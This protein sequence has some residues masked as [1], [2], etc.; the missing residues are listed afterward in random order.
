MSIKEKVSNDYIEEMKNKHA[1]KL[2]RRH[3][4]ILLT[5]AANPSSIGQSIKENA[6]IHG[7][8][9]AVVDDDVTQSFDRIS[10]DSTADTLI[11]CHGAMHLDWIENTPIED[12]KRV[13][14]VNLFGTINVVR[15]FV[16]MSLNRPNR[17]TII[18]IGSMA[19]NKVLN[20]SSAYCASKAGMAHF[21]KCMAWELAPKGFDVFSIHPSNVENS[22]MSTETIEGLKR[23][24]HMSHSEALQY[25]RTGCLRN[26]Q[27][28]KEEISNLVMFL[29]TPDVG[30]LS[31]TN[32]DLGGGVR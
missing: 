3:R 7:H 27:L 25:W 16:K 8:S 5:G 32:F 1:R 31:G 12:V 29:L 14:D 22:P 28:T 4:S 26:S 20:G 21:M 11:M 18:S 23:Y 24:R 30:Y 13:L 10:E 15:A 9:V 6:L 17:K 2:I 19:Y